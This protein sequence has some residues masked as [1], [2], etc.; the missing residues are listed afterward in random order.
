LYRTHSTAE[1][2]ERERESRADTNEEGE[3]KKK[4][5]S[6]EGFAAGDN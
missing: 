4:L 3:K 1:R 2:R 6:E 5:T